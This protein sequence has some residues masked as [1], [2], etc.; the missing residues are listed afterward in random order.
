[1]TRTFPAAS[2]GAKRSGSAWSSTNPVGSVAALRP[3]HLVPAPDVSR[4][5]K[6]DHIGSDGSELKRGDEIEPETGWHQPKID[7]CRH[8]GFPA[9]WS[10][11][12]TAIAQACEK[13][14][15]G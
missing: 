15:D 11:R 5:G 12:A 7:Q 6:R 2:S 14:K 1:M 13:C 9:W 8:R 10:R 3:E 4:L